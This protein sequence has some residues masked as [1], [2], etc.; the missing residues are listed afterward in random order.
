MIYIRLLV[1]VPQSCPTL[2]NPVDYFPL[3]SFVLE[4]VQARILE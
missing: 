3:G 1:L 4:I 2:C